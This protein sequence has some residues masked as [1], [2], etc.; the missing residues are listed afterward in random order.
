MAETLLTSQKTIG[1]I[2]MA[3]ANHKHIPVLYGRFALILVDQQ[4]GPP[5]ACENHHQSNLNT[6]PVLEKAREADIPIIHLQEIHRKELVDYGRELDGNE[7]VHNLEGTPEVELFEPLAPINGEWLIQK[8]RYSGFF[9]TDLDL[10]LRELRIDTVI[11]TGQITDVCV[12]YTAVDAHQYGYVVRVL[13]DC[14]AGSSD[15]AH[16]ASLDAI[17]YLQHGAVRSSAEVI[18]ELERLMRNTESSITAWRIASQEELLNRRWF[19]EETRSL[20][21]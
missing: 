13:E 15:K 11:L 19:V 12:H 10:L 16:E 6:I 5:I 21:K 1:G 20:P 7:T 3:V 9:G 17:E 18:N 4:T 14:V 2:Q 8:R